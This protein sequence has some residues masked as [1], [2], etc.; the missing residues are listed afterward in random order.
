MTLT[1]TCQDPVDSTCQHQLLFGLEGQ[2][3]V[4]GDEGRGSKLSAGLVQRLGHKCLDR[5]QRE[6]HV[7]LC[8]RI[9]RSAKMYE[10]AESTEL[11]TSAAKQEPS[12]WH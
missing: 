4:R 12:Q 9:D 3:L 6:K 5:N 8:Q 11:S 1:C 2:Q 7:G 10:T